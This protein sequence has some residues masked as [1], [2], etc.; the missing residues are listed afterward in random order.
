ME[1]F[2][3]SVELGNFTAAANV[4]KITPALVGKQITPLEKRLGRPCWREQ[5]AHRS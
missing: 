4:F 1:V 5:P 3:G 2:V